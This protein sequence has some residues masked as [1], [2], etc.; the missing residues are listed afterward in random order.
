LSFPLSPTNGQTTTRGNGITY[1]YSASLGTWTRISTGASAPQVL[2]DI[3]NQFDGSKTVFDLKADQ[4]VINTTVD[5]KD[6]EVV[7]NG[8]RLTPYVDTYTYPWITPYD[9]SKGF[10]VV[11]GKLILYNAPYRGDSSFIMT[12]PGSTSRQK[13]RYPFSA[14]TVAL[15]D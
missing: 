11:A 15:G 14:T 9:S 10:R 6:V 12:R 13:R 3:S 8:M 2:N 5:S 1:V 4:T 7:I